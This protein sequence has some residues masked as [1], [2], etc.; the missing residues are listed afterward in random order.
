[1]KKIPYYCVFRMQ[2]DGILRVTHFGIKQRKQM[3]E[4]VNCHLL[5]D[6]IVSVVVRKCEKDETFNV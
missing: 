3:L 2:K 4:F 5:D 1:M 6:F